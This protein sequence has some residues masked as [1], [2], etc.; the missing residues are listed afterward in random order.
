M[1]IYV[2]IVEILNKTSEIKKSIH[3]MTTTIY[4]IPKVLW[5]IDKLT[6]DVLIQRRRE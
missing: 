6:P 5:Q 1:K 3:G 4:P 2:G